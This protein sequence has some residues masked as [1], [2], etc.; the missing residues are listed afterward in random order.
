MLDVTMRG[1]MRQ[2]ASAL[3]QGKSPLLAEDATNGALGDEEGK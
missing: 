1:L 2:K 3:T